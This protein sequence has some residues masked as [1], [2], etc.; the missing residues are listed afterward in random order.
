MRFKDW[1]IKEVGTGTGDIA[2]FA[3]M[4][5]PMVR[6]VWPPSIATM[7]DQDPPGKKKKIKMQ[8]QVKEVKLT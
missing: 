4:T 6:R 5:L 1:L 7:F 8:P 2:C 3:R